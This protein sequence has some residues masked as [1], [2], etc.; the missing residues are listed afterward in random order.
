MK[1]TK[2]E[3]GMEG[4]RIKK[5]VDFFNGLKEA[6]HR[7]SKYALDEFSKGYHKAGRDTIEHVVKEMQSLGFF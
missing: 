3:K 7:G 4:E 6:H 1:D 2:K 5:L